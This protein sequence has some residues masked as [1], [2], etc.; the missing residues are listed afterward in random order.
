MHRA[1]DLVGV[2]RLEECLGG[3]QVGLCA[4]RREVAPSSIPASIAS[5][6]TRLA[7]TISLYCRPDITSSSGWYSHIHSHHACKL[8]LLVLH[9]QTGS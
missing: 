6:A 5:H 8:L 9:A 3:C 1:T 4:G 2:Q 7:A